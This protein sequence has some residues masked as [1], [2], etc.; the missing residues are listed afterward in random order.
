MGETVE[1][2]CTIKPAIL[3]QAVSIFDREVPT[4]PSRISKVWTQTLL[5]NSWY[6]VDQKFIFVRGK[7]KQHI[8]RHGGEER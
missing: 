5:Q 8:G 3:R 2:H 6:H 1:K 4:G 7:T